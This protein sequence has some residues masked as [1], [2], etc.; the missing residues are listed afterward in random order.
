MKHDITDHLYRVVPT[1]MHDTPVSALLRG[2]LWRSPLRPPP[3]NFFSAEI[4]VGDV[5]QEFAASLTPIE[6]FPGL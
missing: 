1:E 5:M 4:A 2:V 3:W 6:P